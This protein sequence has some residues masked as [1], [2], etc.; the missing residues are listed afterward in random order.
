MAKKTKPARDAKAKDPYHEFRFP[1]FD[2][3]GFIEHELEQSYATALTLLF[4][5]GIALVS[6]RLTLL[7]T[8]LGSGLVGIFSGVAGVVGIAAAVVMVYLIGRARPLSGEY[9]KGDWATLIAIYI[10][11]WLGFWA[12]FLNL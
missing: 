3:V 11:L 2:V 9:R 8:S 5:V 12:L 1:E 7:G 4:A 10:F 6:W